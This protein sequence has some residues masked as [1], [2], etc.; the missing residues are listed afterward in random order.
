MRNLS[1]EKRGVSIILDGFVRFS[2]AR[3]ANPEE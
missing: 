3:R 2:Q 1:G